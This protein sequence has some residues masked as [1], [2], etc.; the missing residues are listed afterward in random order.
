MIRCDGECG[1]SKKHKACRAGCSLW[2][3]WLTY[4]GY[5]IKI[6]MHLKMNAPNAGIVL[7]SNMAGLCTIV[8]PR[9][10]KALPAVQV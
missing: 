2:V 1:R 7:S 10:P 8:S 6:Q 5:A 3:K 4:M 9:W